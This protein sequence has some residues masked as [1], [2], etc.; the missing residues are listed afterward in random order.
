MNTE[1]NNNDL[2]LPSWLRFGNTEQD[3]MLHSLADMHTAMLEATRNA[4]RSI[5]INTPDL[6]N[7][8]YDYDPFISALTAFVRN[9]RHASIQILVQ[10]TR[11]A[12][13]RG[14]SL[15]RLA[16]RLTSS[17]EIRKPASKDQYNNS[18][19][20][21]FDNAGFIFKTNHSNS[22]L[23]NKQCKPRATKLLEIFIPAWELS[24]QDIETRRLNI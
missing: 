23:Y 19:F 20:I 14:H 1:P 2:Q 21:V 13:Q 8:L 5:R 6:E 7:D 4:L 11:S 17:I 3:Q 18:S 10:D 24:E 15:I 12:I 16:Q 22:A 9:N